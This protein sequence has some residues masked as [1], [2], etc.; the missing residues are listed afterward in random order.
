MTRNLDPV[1]LEVPFLYRRTLGWIAHAQTTL[2]RLLVFG[3]R[4]MGKSTLLKKLNDY[5][6]SLDPCYIRGADP[7]AAQKLLSW[8][9]NHKPAQ[10][11][12]IDNLDECFS[13]DVEAALRGLSE[14][15]P[16]VGRIVATSRT[17]YQPLN[18]KGVLEQRPA[19]R[20]RESWEGS[21][22]LSTF[23]VEW[24][25]PWSPPERWKLDM[26]DAIQSALEAGLG[27]LPA[28]AG[29]SGGVRPVRS[30]E[31][32]SWLVDFSGGHPWIVGRAFLR[33]IQL[34]EVDPQ[35]AEVGP[36]LKAR[37]EEGLGGALQNHA[38]FAVAWLATEDAGSLAELGDLAGGKSTS[39]RSGLMR[40]AGLAKWDTARES[41]VLAAE[42]LREPVRQ[43]LTGL[44][45]KEG[46]RKE[47]A[48]ELK[49]AELRAP[50]LVPDSSLPESAGT[51]RF[52]REGR[53]ITV[54]LKGSAWRLIRLLAE[55]GGRPVPL[56][57]I[58]DKAGASSPAAVRS[59][60]QRLRE[61]LGRAGFGELVV[62]VAKR[63]YALSE[64]VLLPPVPRSD[65]DF[66]R[67]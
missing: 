57:V 12:L 11:L 20:R 49:A 61:R 17:P 53:W 28:A 50:E 55:A 24:L 7:D 52:H 59:V 43:V 21:T 48:P 15:D 42:V 33:L 23:C 45:A 44:Q 5:L 40:R 29:D 6:R 22:S 56:E 63:G 51:L 3:G 47:T 65:G 25:D 2:R 58:T 16:K 36:L 9:S 62:N 41:L 60:I 67:R 37:V 18:E 30:S 35:L 38:A 34:I 39:D 54:E 64:D 1:P 13:P 66:R 19:N 46:A 10:P 14:E 27:A 4:G 26:L 8:A 31:L 32:A